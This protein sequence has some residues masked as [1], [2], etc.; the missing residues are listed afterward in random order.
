[1]HCNIELV[2]YN[3]SVF[4]IYVY[5]DLGMT[6]CPTC[7]LRTI[8]VLFKCQEKVDFVNRIYWLSQSLCFRRQLYSDSKC[9]SNLKLLG[10]T[11]STAK[12]CIS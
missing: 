10:R 9:Q 6:M 5:Q 3:Y 12:T 1:M 4:Y 2:A 11:S 8:R 7:S